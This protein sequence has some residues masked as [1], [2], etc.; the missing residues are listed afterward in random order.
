MTPEFKEVPAGLVSGRSHAMRS[1]ANPSTKNLR[2]IVSCLVGPGNVHLEL[3]HNH[4]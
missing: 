2:V 1:E 3:D 4:C